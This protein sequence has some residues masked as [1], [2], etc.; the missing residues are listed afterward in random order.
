ME[1]G[2]T[3]RGA[4]MMIV[5]GL[6]CR[7][8]CDAGEILRLVEQALAQTA[9]PRSALSALAAPAFKAEA[10]GPREAAKALGLPLLLISDDALKAAEPR[11]VTP[12]A[13]A[14]KATG[15]ASVAESAALAAAGEGATLL[16]PRIKGPSATCALAKRATP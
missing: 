2:K 9:Q 10:A 14:L 13:A 1:R 7:K 11:S 3:T 6:G 5:A 12:S 15:H 8:D 4:A 16:L